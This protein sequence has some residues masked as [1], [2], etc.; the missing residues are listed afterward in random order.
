[1]ADRL[2][3]AVAAD[4]TVRGIAVVT[5]ALVDD[6]RRRHGT[7]PT[8]TAA[9]GRALSGALL[10]AA[11][12][13]R[14]ER[15]SLEFVGDGPLRGILVDAT[16]DGHAR[17]FVRRP[18]THLPPKRGKLDVGGALGRGSLCVMRVPVDGR[19]VYRSVVPLTTGEIGDDVAHYLAH[20]AQIPSVVGLGVFVDTAGRTVAAGGYLLQTLPGATEETTRALEAQVRAAPSPSELV[21]LHADADAMLGTLLAPLGARVLAGHAVRFQCRCDE[22]R[23]RRA[24]V[25][26]GPEEIARAL[27]EDGG[28][29]AVC[30]FCNAAYRLGVDETRALLTRAGRS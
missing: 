26:M 18:Q 1:V 22:D 17:G 19:Q 20:S 3:R 24:I 14:D 28:I 5:T 8:A 29:E 12:L 13:K 7:L 11:T 16:P 23:V 2:A 30:E 4:R 27:A 21:R 10:L 15:L 25:A 6:A 9:L